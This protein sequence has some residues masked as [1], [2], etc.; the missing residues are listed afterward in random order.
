[1]AVMNWRRIGLLLLIPAALFA[2]GP[3]RSGQF[4]WWDRPI[5]KGL[6]LTDMQ[7][8]Q[9]GTITGQYRKSTMDARAAVDKAEADLDAVFNEE[10]VDPRKGADAVDRLAKA[11]GDMTKVVSEMT[12]KMRMVLTPQQWQELQRR[13]ATAGRGGNKASV[14][15]NG[16]SGS[17]GSGSAPNQGRGRRGR[18]PKGPPPSQPP[19]S[20][21]AVSPPPA[22]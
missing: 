14:A 16:G 20:Q 22:N 10:N 1:M 18:G 17:G 19:S 15:D 3:P 11:R 21:P 8:N 6:N 9:I 7:R 2:Q 5:A 12:L 4:P 13:Q